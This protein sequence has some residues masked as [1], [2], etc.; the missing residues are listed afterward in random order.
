MRGAFLHDV[1]DGP[2][3]VA[4]VGS[5]WRRFHSRTFLTSLLVSEVCAEFPGFLRRLSHTFL[6]FSSKSLLVASFSTCLESGLMK[7]SV[8]K[9]RK[10]AGKV[11]ITMSFFLKREELT[12]RSLELFVCFG[13]IYGFM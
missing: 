8:F 7:R 4:V 13:C 9:S 10:H 6:F 2:L 12:I 3:H 5:S 11:L 1:K